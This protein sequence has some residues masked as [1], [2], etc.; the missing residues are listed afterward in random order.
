M[1]VC[2]WWA[3]NKN[4][5]NTKFAKPHCGQNKHQWVCDFHQ[6]KFFAL[7]NIWLILARIR[8]GGG[9]HS[10]YLFLVLVRALLH[11]SELRMYVC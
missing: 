8:Q 4:G 2:D 6:R 3:I 10:L 5:T 1:S 7:F 9:S 11:E